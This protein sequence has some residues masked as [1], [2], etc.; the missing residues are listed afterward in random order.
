MWPNFCQVLTWWRRSRND[1]PAG[2]T[3]SRSEILGYN[4]SINDRA[5]YSYIYERMKMAGFPMDQLMLV[6][7]R[8]YPSNAMLNTLVNDNS[9]FL[10]GCPIAANSSEEK[11][12]LG[13]GRQLDGMA[14][15]RDYV[16]R[17]LFSNG[18]TS[19]L[20]N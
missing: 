18:Y 9:A 14:H 12:I 2:Y 20:K 15:A 13:P 11:W 10:T 3:A 19:S 17:E 5:S 7:D 1:D 4:G 16:H 8:G 6:T